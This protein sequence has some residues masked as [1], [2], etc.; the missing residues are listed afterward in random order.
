MKPGDK[1]EGRAGCKPGK[2]CALLARILAETAEQMPKAGGAGLTEGIVFGKSATPE[3]IFYIFYMTGKGSKAKPRTTI[4]IEWCPFCRGALTAESAEKLP[5]PIVMTPER[6]A[7]LV[8]EA[9]V[10]WMVDH[11]EAMWV[12][13]VPDRDRGVEALAAWVKDRLH[14]A[15]LPEGLRQ[16]LGLAHLD[17]CGHY[18]C[19]SIPCEGGE[20]CAWVGET[21]QETAPKCCGVKTEGADRS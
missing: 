1:I 6:L 8:R 19:P 7:R 20:G 4:R 15:D 18:L 17:E 9:L 16:D 5:R 14:V 12:D 11:G 2:P 21:R 13:D 10:S 3:P